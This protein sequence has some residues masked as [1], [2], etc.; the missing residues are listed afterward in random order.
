M[1]YKQKSKQVY[2]QAACNIHKTHCKSNTHFTHYKSKKP[3][4]TVKST[5]QY[6]RPDK[7]NITQYLMGSSI[8]HKYTHFT[9]ITQD[10]LGSSISHK[11][12]H[13]TNITQYLLGS[14]ISIHTSPTIYHTCG[15]W[16]IIP[17]P[18]P[19]HNNN[20]LGTFY[21]PVSVLS[22]LAKILEKAIL[23]YI[24]SQHGY[25]INYS[26]ETVL[27]DINITIATGFNQKHA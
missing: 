22:T 10:L 13:F 25:K 16:L 14:S 15:N 2:Q 24:P 4:N 21:R 9:N 23:P 20:N 11:Y 18:K 6:I 1:Q 5:T 17:I 8:S 27:Q 12:T 7:I 3:S 19:K 26:A